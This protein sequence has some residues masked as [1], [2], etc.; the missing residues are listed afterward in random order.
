MEGETMVASL[1]LQLER[2]KENHNSKQKHRQG[3]K[4]SQHR[5]KTISHDKMC[6]TLPVLRLQMQGQKQQT[7]NRTG[8]E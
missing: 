2:K 1:A 3:E 8:E 4:I 7:K 6:M 5:S